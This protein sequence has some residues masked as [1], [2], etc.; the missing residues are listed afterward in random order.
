MLAVGAAV[1]QEPGSKRRCW[2]SATWP[3]G[4]WNA[5]SEVWP[6]T[7]EQ[8]D[9]CHKLANVLDKLPKRLQGKAKAML[10]EV[11]YADTR[12]VAE[13]GIDAFAA[14]YSPSMTKRSNACSRTGRR[15]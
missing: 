11:M 9:W 12:E 4:F 5:V 13:E 7:L 6:E 1:P 10:H 3:L 15:C 14:E 2:R 8:R